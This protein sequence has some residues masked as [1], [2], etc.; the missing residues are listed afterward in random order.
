MFNWLKHCLVSDSQNKRKPDC[1]SM[2]FSL[3]PQ[4]QN[5]KHSRGEFHSPLDSCDGGRDYVICRT[6]TWLAKGLKRACKLETD[7]S[8][9]KVEE[10]PLPLLSSLV[11]LNTW[12]SLIFEA[13]TIALISPSQFSYTKLYPSLNKTNPKCYKL[14]YLL[15]FNNFENIAKAETKRDVEKQV[16]KQMIIKT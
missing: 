12:D 7:E 16:T 8:L 4:N 5:S 11:F 10:F 9:L 2:F 14:M 6:I 1:Q 3:R 13:S 15:S